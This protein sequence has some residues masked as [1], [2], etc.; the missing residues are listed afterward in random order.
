MQKKKTEGC[1]RVGNEISARVLV[2]T[3]PKYYSNIVEKMQ[4]R[5]LRQYTGMKNLRGAIGQV[6]PGKTG[7]KKT[8]DH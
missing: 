4:K 7:R 6:G 1:I 5:T 2:R 8:E 3:K